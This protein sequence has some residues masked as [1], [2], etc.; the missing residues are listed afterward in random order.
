MY[1][2]QRVSGSYDGIAFTGVVS[3]ARTLTVKTD[4]VEHWI[5]LDAPV[6]V[7]GEPR[8]MLICYTTWE[9]EPSA[10]VKF[11]DSLTTI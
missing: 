5:S 10:Y 6:T 4:A 9:G 3:A 2:G 8:N 11:K 1:H 7:F